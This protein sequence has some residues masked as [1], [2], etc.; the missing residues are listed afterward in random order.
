MASERFQAGATGLLGG[1]S[2]SG[3]RNDGSMIWNSALGA[4]G[5]QGGEQLHNAIEQ[6][7][8]YMVWT[9]LFVMLASLVAEWARHGS[10][11][12]AQVTCGHSSA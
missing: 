7:G 5:V 1:L 8:L 9:S 4:L 10:E 6:E 11:R 2:L 12:D 3:L